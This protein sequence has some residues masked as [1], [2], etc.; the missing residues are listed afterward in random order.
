MNQ[1]LVLLLAVEEE[2]KPI[3][4]RDTLREPVKLRTQWLRAADHTAS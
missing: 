4:R 2:Q 1:A 3:F